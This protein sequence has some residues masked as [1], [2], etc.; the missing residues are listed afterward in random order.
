MR[1]IVVLVVKVVMVVSMT[2]RLHDCMTSRHLSALPPFPP[3]LKVFRPEMVYRFAFIEIKAFV[4][5]LCRFIVLSYFEGNLEQSSFRACSIT[6]S[7]SFRP[8]PV[9]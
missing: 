1:K 9:P 2:A 5:V 7:I 3:S 4:K 8:A 6:P